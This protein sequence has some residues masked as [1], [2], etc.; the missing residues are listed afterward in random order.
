[1]TMLRSEW[2]WIVIA[3]PMSWFHLCGDYRW[4]LDQIEATEVAP[5]REMFEIVAM[6][7]ARGVDIGTQARYCCW[8]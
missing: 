3:R 5:R 6:V 1:M 2:K 7:V 4:S 8:A